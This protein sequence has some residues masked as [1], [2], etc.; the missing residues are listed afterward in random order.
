M[1]PQVL[2][3]LGHHVIPLNAQVS[4]RFPARPPEPTPGNLA[5]FSRMVPELGVDFAF[6]HDGD[7]DR[8]VMIDAHGNIVPDSILAILALRSLNISSGVA[9]ISENTLRRGFS[10][11]NS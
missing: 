3:L 5:D 4:W 1:T 10:P 6:A 7:A 2:N 8:L 11:D 9:V